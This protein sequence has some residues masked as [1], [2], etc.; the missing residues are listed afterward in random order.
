MNRTELISYLKK[1]MIE[2]IDMYTKIP[3][4]AANNEIYLLSPFYGLKDYNRK[5]IGRLEE[6][7]IF[8]YRITDIAKRWIRKNSTLKV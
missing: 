3:Y 2:G 5:H 8:Y 1:Q 7:P 4:I 6:D